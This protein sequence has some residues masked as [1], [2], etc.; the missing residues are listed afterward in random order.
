[1][2]KSWL[3][4]SLSNLFIASCIGFLLRI[5][6]FYKIS[7]PYGN[8]LHAHSH[9]ALLGWLYLFFYIFIY[10]MYI[11]KTSKNKKRFTG[12]FWVTQFSIIGMLFSFPIQGYAFFSI[13]FSSLHIVCS[14]YFCWISWKNISHVYSIDNLYL[15]TALI[16][17]LFSTLGVWSLGA[18]LPT[19]GKSSIAYPIAIQFFLHFQINGWFLFGIFSF[20][21]KILKN[22]NSPIPKYSYLFYFFNLGTAILT[23]FLPISWHIPSFIFYILNSIGLL[24]QLFSLFLFWKYIH[25]SL[26]V[27]FKKKSFFIYSLYILFI[28][29]F[30][31]KIIFQTFQ[32][33]PEIAEHS[34]LIKNLTIGFIHLIVL[35][36][37]TLFLFIL[38]LTFIS[39]K[40]INAFIKTGIIIFT[41]AFLL[42]DILLILQGAFLFMD[43]GNITGYFIII[44][45]GSILFPLGIILFII[46]L[47]NKK[48]NFNYLS[49]YL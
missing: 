14:Y 4:T 40:K 11:P 41:I 48:Y 44:S 7:I 10:W 28:L 17:M 22:Y 23:F 16:L 35:G 38:I 21:L 27:I 31:V 26:L 34:Y 36:I 42:T 18:I 13:L 12:C 2:K 47:C 1:M 25:P 3:M 19:L 37:Y 49:K 43:W 45:W 32:W 6:Q 46:G 9:V 30:S 20:I 15:K 33:I 24:F 29:L 39:T 8:F 5:T